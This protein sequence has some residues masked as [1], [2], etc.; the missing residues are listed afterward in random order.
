MS[1]WLIWTG[2]ALKLWSPLR[3]PGCFPRQGEWRGWEG[4][5]VALPLGKGPAMEELRN[6]GKEVSKGVSAIIACFEQGPGSDGNRSEQRHWGRRRHSGQP[7]LWAGCQCT[8]PR[9]CQGCRENVSSHSTIWAVETRSDFTLKLRAEHF[10]KSWLQW[11]E[12]GTDLLQP[13]CPPQATA[14]LPAPVGIQNSSEKTLRL[15]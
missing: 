13:C 2:T 9:T 1:Q 5:E 14:H 10:G 4:C 12:W 15:C 11:G 6:L 7:G 8:E 3:A